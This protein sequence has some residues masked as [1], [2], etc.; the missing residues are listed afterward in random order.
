MNKNRKTQL[1]NGFVKWLVEGHNE[2]VYYQMKS[3]L[4]DNLQEG[5]DF[6]EVLDFM[7]ENVKGHLVWTE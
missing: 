3:Y 1:T 2:D 5:E 4:E 7:A 6:G